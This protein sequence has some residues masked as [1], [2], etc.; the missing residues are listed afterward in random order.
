MLG[1]TLTLEYVQTPILSSV[2][3]I[4]DVTN[5]GNT[6]YNFEKTQTFEVKVVAVI[7]DRNNS[8]GGFLGSNNFFSSQQIQEQAIEIT[9]DSVDFIEAGFLSVDVFIDNFQ[10]LDSTIEDLQNKTI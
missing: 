9:P 5:P 2:G 8:N 1:K 7:D 4:Y 6:E 3:S 10:S